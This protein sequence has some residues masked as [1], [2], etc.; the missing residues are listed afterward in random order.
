MTPEGKV[1]A[2]V[3]ALFKAR[4]VWF[5]MPMGQ[6]YGRAGV[7]DFLACVNGHFLGVETKAKG[8]KPTALQ[9]LEGSRIRDAGGHF[10]IIYPDNI[11]ELKELLE[12]LT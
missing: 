11:D 6:M 5:C 7:P 9:K 12:R 10:L 4:G 3:K 1:K 2:Q 8:G